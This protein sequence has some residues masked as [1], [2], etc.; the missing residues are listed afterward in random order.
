MYNLEVRENINRIFI[1]LAKKDK[2]SFEYITK[3]ITEI[4]ENPHHFKPLKAP[5]QNFRRVHIGNFVL[6][7]S[8]DEKRKVVIIEKYEHHNKVYK[9]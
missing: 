4:R 8:I 2:V 9:I 5:M 6:V 3:K 7:Y 1:K